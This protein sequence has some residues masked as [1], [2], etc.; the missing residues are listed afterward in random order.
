MFYYSLKVVYFLWPCLSLSTFH[1]CY[2]AC[3]FKAW[4]CVVLREIDFLLKICDWFLVCFPC[5]VKLLELYFCYRIYVSEFRD[6]INVSF[7]QLV[8]NPNN[9]STLIT[10]IMQNT[11]RR[12]IYRS[13]EGHGWKKIFSIVYIISVF[14]V[15]RSVPKAQICRDGRQQIIGDFQ[16]VRS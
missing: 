15:F 2:I 5:G 9:E 13:C 16:N 1:T 4:G 8:I 12:Y 10:R 11:N 3:R 14:S 6:M 7:V